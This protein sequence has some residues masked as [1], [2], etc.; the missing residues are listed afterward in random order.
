MRRTTLLVAAVLSLIALPASAQDRSTDH[1]YQGGPKTHV[2]HHIGKRPI[3][4]AT[5]SQSR[6][7]QHHYQGGPK[8]VV[9]HHIGGKPAAKK[10][11]KTKK[12]SAA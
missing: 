8:T 10:K 1:H 9:P 5:E 6:A 12:K 2:P 11:A 3:G 7:G 4:N